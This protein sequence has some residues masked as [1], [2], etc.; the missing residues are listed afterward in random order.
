VV[1]LAG[2]VSLY[3][4]FA[5]TETSLDQRD[6]TKNLTALDGKNTRCVISQNSDF[7]DTLSVVVDGFTIQNGYAACGGGINI[8][9]NT[10]VNNCIVKNNVASSQGSAIY[11]KGAVIKNLQIVDNSYSD[12]LSYTVWLKNSTMDSCEV[13]HNNTYTA[14]AIYADNSKISNC[15]MEGNVSE[16]NN[17]YGSTFSATR[18]DNCKFVNTDGCGASVDLIGSSVMRNCLLNGNTNV[19]TNIV[20]L[21]S[22]DALLE[23]C[24]ILDN[25]INSVVLYS[26]GKVNRCQIRG[27]TSSSHAAAMGY[28]G[29]IYNSLVCDNVC[30]SDAVIVSLYDYT[31]MIN[32]TVVRNETK[33]SN[34]VYMFS[35]T[36]RNSI[37][38]GNKK[39]GSSPSMFSLSGSNTIANN[40]LECAFVEGNI[41][42]SMM[43]AD[44]TDAENGDYSLSANSYCINAG[45][46]VTDTLDLFGNVRNQGGAVDMGAIESAHASAPSITCTDTVYVKLG[47]NGDGSSWDAAFGDIQ[48]AIFA[49][50][51]DGKHHQIWVAAGTYYGDTT[52][53]AVVTLASGVSLYGGFSGNEVS[54]DARDVTKNPT[55]LD[56]GNKRCVVSQSIGFPKEN[57]VVVDGFTI[58]NGFSTYGGGANI[59]ANT[60]I[61]NC[62]LKNNT[63]GSS[64]A[65]RAESARITN[66]LFIEN[67]S[68]R[69]QLI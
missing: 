52:L 56:G 11:A 16:K 59:F 17:V 43:H 41:N 36:L 19:G 20:H 9:A 64:G 21:S 25:S 55:I 33:S 58:Q 1:N 48:Q 32:C 27:N 46:N 39:N 68:S 22:R 26:Q 6:A 24:Q 50:A 51:S 35:S 42:G 66:S 18:V 14:C 57:P 15:E 29:A 54:L 28:G 61:N 67:V 53:P 31:C 44:F 12:N 5:G 69:G 23:D 65:L 38:V 7:V 63:S 37:F 49:A 60:T 2:G 45:S 8:N 4:G 3:G 10:T 40:M 13:K 34:V 47:A 30:T 62:I